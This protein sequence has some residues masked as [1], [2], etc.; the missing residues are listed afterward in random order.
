M[1]ET[2]PKKRG[3]K[4]LAE[5]GQSSPQK[6][7][8]VV[9]TCIEDLDRVEMP[10]DPKEYS[11]KSNDELIKEYKEHFASLHD[12]EEPECLFGP[13]R[14]RKGTIVSKTDSNGTQRRQRPI[15]DPETIEFVKESTGEG[16]YQIGAVDWN[17]EVR[18]IVGSEDVGCIFFRD[19]V[20]TSVKK[21]KPQLKYIYLN[22]LK[23]HKKIEKTA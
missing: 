14:D 2:E 13:F 16:I 15:L 11:A 17:V 6:V 12:G 1:S 5:G 20:D 8:F 19:P 21:Q 3:R 10:G 7:V 18:Y 22:E 4:S 9:G 23:S